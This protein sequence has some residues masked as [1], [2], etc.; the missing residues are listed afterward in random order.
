[1]Q[2]VVVQQPQEVHKLHALQVQQPKLRA[3][4][5]MLREEITQLYKGIG[6]KVIQYRVL[7][8]EYDEN[9]ETIAKLQ[10]QLDQEE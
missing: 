7:K 2:N 3:G 8:K 10:K 1:M 6:A 9:R 5:K 4:M